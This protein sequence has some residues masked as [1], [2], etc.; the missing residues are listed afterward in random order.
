MRGR[1]DRLNAGLRVIVTV[2][3]EKDL[4]GDLAESCIESCDK[5]GYVPGFVTRRNDHAHVKGARARSDD[6]RR[7]HAASQTRRS[8]ARDASVLTAHTTGAAQ[9]C[10]SASVGD[11]HS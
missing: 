10:A 2:V 8:P 7:L 6:G 5:R 3:N 11:S 4:G 9:R 1:R